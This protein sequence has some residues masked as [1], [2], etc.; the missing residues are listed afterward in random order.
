MQHCIE[1]AFVASVHRRRPRIGHSSAGMVVQIENMNGAFLDCL[2]LEDLFDRLG[3]DPNG[4]TAVLGNW[5]AA[6]DKVPNT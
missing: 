2:A 5:P 1:P 3:T 4:G 6:R